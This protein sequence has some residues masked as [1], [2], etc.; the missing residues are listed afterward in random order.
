MTLHLGGVGA[1]TRAGSPLLSAPVLGH[2]L[3]MTRKS[4]DAERIRFIAPRGTSE[5]YA[6]VAELEG[7]PVEGWI[8]VVLHDEAERILAR[9]GRDTSAMPPPHLER[10][11]RLQPPLDEEDAP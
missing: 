3:S 11:P 7:L 6:E 2:D 4:H 8:R 9:E 1:A 10:P 5:L